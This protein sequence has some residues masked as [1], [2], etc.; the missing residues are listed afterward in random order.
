MANLLPD[1]ELILLDQYTGD[2]VVCPCSRQV[3]HTISSY[4][5]ILLTAYKEKHMSKINIVVPN[6]HVSYDIIM[7]FHGVKTN[8]GNLEI[9][10]HTI[11]H[12][13]CSNF[14]GLPFDTRVLSKL[15]IPPRGLHLLWN[16]TEILDSDDNVIIAINKIIPNDYDLGTIQPNI[17][18]RM[19]DVCQTYDLVSGCEDGTVNIFDVQ[20]K[21]C[22]HS[23]RGHVHWVR[24]VCYSPNGQYIA[25]GGH[26]GHINIYN[27]KTGELSRALTSNAKA[28]KSS[29][30]LSF[31]EQWNGP[32]YSI[33]YSS[34]G[35]KIIN[36]NHSNV[37]MWD[38]ETGT[39]N[40]IIGNIECSHSVCCHSPN[41]KQIA[42]PWEWLNRMEILDLETGKNH[43]LPI[44]PVHSL[45]YS[46][47]GK[48]IAAGFGYPAHIEIWDCSNQCLI[49]ALSKESSSVTSLSYSPRGLQLAA[50]YHNGT[51]KIWDVEKGTAIK[52]LNGTIGSI[53]SICY[54]PDGRLLAS[55]GYS[56]NIE[57]WNSEAGTLNG[58]LK[59]KSDTLS[60]CFSTKPMNK[61]AKMLKR[62]DIWDKN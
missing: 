10:H 17:L 1:L 36:I 6:A 39:P 26:D 32:V 48:Q 62:Q 52:T 51:I 28:E 54:S 29:N 21:V 16:L 45:C 49:K 47:D 5:M 13:E 38:V 55:G 7:Q 61:I 34:D 14:F 58:I 44:G 4:F 25:S 18:D 46:P 59:G 42:F 31:Q 8:I 30:L 60:L 3:V 23:I 24:K 27:A 20:S 50:G 19:I 22:R 37:K 53:R 9:W 12:I 40:I 43:K 15:D 11:G 2:E 57:I 33:F 56:P 41:R 35:Q